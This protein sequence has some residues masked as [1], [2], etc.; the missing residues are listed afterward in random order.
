MN[1]LKD[2]NRLRFARVRDVKTPSRS[3]EG[4]AGLDFYMPWDL[5][6]E[7]ISWNGMI[8]INPNIEGETVCLIEMAPHARV[9]I[10]SGI[11][12]L[13]E[14][15]SSMLTAANKSGLATKKGLI[16]T[17]QVVDSPYT[18]EV[19]IGIFNTSDHYV[20][21][22]RGEKLTQFIHVPIYL[23]TPEEISLTEYEGL[24]ETWGT[25]GIKGFGSSDNQ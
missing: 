18:G 8:N 20:Q 14:P 24:A 16:F 23:T 21:I 2:E 12:V 19:H 6:R 4:D 25:R 5:K 7:D 17:A 11:K 22:Q 9:L 13:L 10:P 1:Q 3:N 15:K